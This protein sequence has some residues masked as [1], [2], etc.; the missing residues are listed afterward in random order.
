MILTLVEY[1]LSHLT[2]NRSF[3]GQV[4]PAYHLATL[5][6]KQ[7]YNTKDKTRNK[8]NNYFESLQIPAGCPLPEE[9]ILPYLYMLFRKSQ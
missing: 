6:T 1:C 7:T 5:L 8:S 3:Q 2:H 4:R 9:N